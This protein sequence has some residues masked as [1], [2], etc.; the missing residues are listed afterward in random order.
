MK[1]PPP[2][3]P[4][5][6]NSLSLKEW[7]LRMPSKGEDSDFAR[8]K[9]TLPYHRIVTASIAAIPEFRMP[10][11]RLLAEWKSGE[12]PGAHVVFE[13]AFVPFLD[14]IARAGHSDVLTRF[15]EFVERALVEGDEHVFEAVA[16][17]LLEPLATYPTLQGALRSK[18]GPRAK[19]LVS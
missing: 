6:P 19:V 15:A 1:K 13:D 14:E 18:L 12:K 9:A 11:Q 4:Q 17:S 10:Y 7:L 3:P 16:Q 5:R 8:T 2:K